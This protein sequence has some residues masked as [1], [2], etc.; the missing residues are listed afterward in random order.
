[1]GDVIDFL[2]SHGVYLSV[3]VLCPRDLQE[4]IDTHFLKKALE[5]GAI[6]A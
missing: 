5:E 1:V 4:F 2:P 3:K 6:L